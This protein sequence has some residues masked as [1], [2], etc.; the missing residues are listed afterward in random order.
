MRRRLMFLSHC[1]PWPPDKGEKIRAWHVLVH[2]ARDFDVYL[3]CV[4]GEAYDEAHIAK[5]GAVC[6]EVGVFPIDRRVQKFRALARAWPGRPLMP[7]FYYSP[8]L[9]AWVDRVLAGSGVDGVYIYTVAMAPYVASRNSPMRILDA[10]DIDSEKWAEYALTSR[11]PMRAV[12]AREARNLLAYER[13][14]A[15]AC[16]RTL[17]VS[18]AEAA[19]FVALA[20]ESAGMVDYVENGVDMNRFS[21]ALSFDSPYGDARPVFVFTGHMDY[22]PNED[23]VTWFAS[24]VMPAVRLAVIDACFWIVGANPNAAVRSLAGLPGVVVTGR[25]AD[26]RPYLA[27]AAAVVCPLRIARG[28]QNKLLEG[29][30]MGRPVIASSAA[31]HGVRAVAGRDLLV[32]ESAAGFVAACISVMGGARVPMGAAARAAMEAGYAWKTTL[33]RLDPAMTELGGAYRPP[34]ADQ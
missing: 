23:A 26:T 34:K 16:A 1:L 20:P 6:A 24:A 7:D 30:A 14:A 10:V 31:F 15:H 19:R 8:A 25:V 2:L 17:F 5:L 9:Q 3:G 12:W 18:A 11:F 32:A 22:W 27:H 29:M 28:I 21:P 33:A 13:A 4:T